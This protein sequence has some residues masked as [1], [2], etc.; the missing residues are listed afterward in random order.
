M[1][2][3]NKK[4]PFCLSD[5]DTKFL[6]DLGKEMLNQDTR[7]TAQPYGLTVQKKEIIITDEEFADN[8]TLF[9]EGD[10]VAEGLK[11]AKT[12]LIDEIHEKLIDADDDTQKLELAKELGI[13]LNVDDD[14]DLQSYIRDREELRDYCYYPTMQ[15]WVVDERMVFTFSDREAREYAKRG[16]NYR[17][18]GVYLGRSPIMSRLCEILLKIG[19]QAK[20]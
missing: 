6:M 7:S 9:S 17:T 16:E 14:D 1:T 18:Y 12:Y 2:Q 5:E 3:D 13:L 11:Q 4:V 15:R 19:E 8:W 20:G 10:A